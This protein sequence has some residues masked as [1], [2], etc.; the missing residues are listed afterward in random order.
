MAFTEKRLAGPT[1]ISN[2]TQ[3]SLYT[4]PTNQT[5][6]ALVKQIMLTN[7]ASSEAKTVYLN[8]VPSGQVVTN[9]NQILSNVSIPA[10]ETV[11]L[12]LEQVM[13]SGDLL[14]VYSQGSSGSLLNVTISGIENAGGMVVSGLADNAVTTAK[15]ADSNVT[16]AKLGPDAFIAN[17][18]AGAIVLMEMM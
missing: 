6:T 3:T 12:D 2:F 14:S 4:C 9:S 1:A 7:T 5:T 10:N 15:I 17:N 8:L 13:T 16:A 11:I 18:Q